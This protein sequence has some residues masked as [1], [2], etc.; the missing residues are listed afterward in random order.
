MEKYE[1]YEEIEGKLWSIKSDMDS[2]DFVLNKL[3]QK[4]EYD[5]EEN[6]RRCIRAVQI[7]YSEINTRLKDTVMEMDKLVSEQMKAVDHSE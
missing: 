7:M 2:I 3:N 4:L 6:S 1:E 5:R